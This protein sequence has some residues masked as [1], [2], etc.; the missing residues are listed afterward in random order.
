MR[1]AF[2]LNKLFD[3]TKLMKYVNWVIPEGVTR[4]LI[5]AM[6]VQKQIFHILRSE[7]PDY[8]SS[9]IVKSVFVPI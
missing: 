6:H 2:I 5:A 3:I 9:L 4:I 8:V 7:K 1:K